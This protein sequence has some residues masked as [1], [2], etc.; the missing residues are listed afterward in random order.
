MTTTE[1]QAKHFLRSCR[2]LMVMALDVPDD[3]SHSDAVWEDARL[4]ALSFSRA[5][6]GYWAVRQPFGSNVHVEIAKNGTYGEIAVAGQNG[7]NPKRAG[8]IAVDLTRA[9][10]WCTQVN[11]VLSGCE[12]PQRVS[13]VLRQLTENMSIHELRVWASE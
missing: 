3:E 5:G 11:G 6:T 1:G 8:I 10:A 9:A 12:G 7:M 2:D 13:R 4:L